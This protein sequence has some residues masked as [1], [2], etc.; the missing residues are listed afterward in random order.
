[1]DQYDR[2]VDQLERMYANHEIT[3]QEFHAEMAE[4]NRDYQAAAEQAADQ[5]YQDEMARWY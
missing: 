5:A 2:E 4:L 3:E 1:M